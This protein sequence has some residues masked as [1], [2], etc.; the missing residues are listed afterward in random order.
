MNSDTL[1]YD[2]SIN[3]Y[4]I[5][6]KPNQI[7]IELCD[8]DTVEGLDLSKLSNYIKE[9]N[10]KPNSTTRSVESFLTPKKIISFNRACFEL[11]KKIGNKFRR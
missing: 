1:Y 5:P 6:D 2:G 10:S 3:I 11:S 9:N 7:L 8:K 4:R